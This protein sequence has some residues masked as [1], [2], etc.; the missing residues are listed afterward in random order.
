M[1][2]V[3]RIKK[4]QTNIERENNKNEKTTQV[5]REEEKKLL[6]NVH[7]WKESQIVKSNIV[8]EFSV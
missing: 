2:K 3:S 7:K 4:L 6:R 1:K 8:R 5:K